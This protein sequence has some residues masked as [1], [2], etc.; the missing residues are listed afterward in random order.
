MGLKHGLIR[1]MESE[2]APG[3]ENDCVREVISCWT[4]V[5]PSNIGSQNSSMNAEL[6]S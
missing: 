3:E 1:E 2:Q 5:I 4:D 6:Q